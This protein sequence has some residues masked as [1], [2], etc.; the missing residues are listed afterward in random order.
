LS[1]DA[2]NGVEFSGTSSELVIPAGSTKAAVP[3]EILSTMTGAITK[4]VVVVQISESSG[5]SIGSSSLC[6]VVIQY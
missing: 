3:V 6:G 1:Q 5:A 2:V 4:K